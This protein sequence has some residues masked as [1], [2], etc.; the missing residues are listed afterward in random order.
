MS[1]TTT[2][3]LRRDEFRTPTVSALE[4]TAEGCDSSGLTNPTF[5]AAW[6]ELDRCD[7][8]ATHAT[9]TFTGTTDEINGVFAALAD[10]GATNE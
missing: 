6:S 1:D 7:A 4:V 10:P 5:D 3:S 9:V 2:A 8:W